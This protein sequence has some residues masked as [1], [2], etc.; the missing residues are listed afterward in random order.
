M[1]SQSPQ[2]ADV[3]CEVPE[4]DLVCGAASHIWLED[5]LSWDILEESLGECCWNLTPLIWSRRRQA[6]RG[7]STWPLA[8]QLACGSARTWCEFQ[9]LPKAVLYRLPFASFSR[10]DWCCSWS[11][12]SGGVI[13][14][15]SQRHPVVIQSPIHGGVLQPCLYE[16]CLFKPKKRGKNP[17][18]NNEC[19]F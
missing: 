17:H 10:S 11:F 2:S 18:T 4:K 14:D 13:R 16:A 7:K 15:R 12:F 6:P 8:T 9:E 5:P 1:T 19:Q 3:P